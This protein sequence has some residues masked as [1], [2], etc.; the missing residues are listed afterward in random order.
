MPPIREA[1]DSILP[2]RSGQNCYLARASAASSKGFSR[3][4]QKRA[5]GLAAA[6]TQQTHEP[7]VR[8]AIT[9]S[10]DQ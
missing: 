6:T 5:H 4:S 8:L 3:P 9:R 10:R 2:F 1:H 7:Q